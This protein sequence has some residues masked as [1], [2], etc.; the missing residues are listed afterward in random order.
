[1]EELTKEQERIIEKEIRK[2]IDKINTYLEPEDI[3]LCIQELKSSIRTRSFESFETV[4]KNIPKYAYEVV[5][6]K[7]IKR[8]LNCDVGYLSD[9]FCIFKIPIKSYNENNFEIE[10]QKINIDKYSCNKLLH[11]F[12]IYPLMFNNCIFDNEINISIALKQIQKLSFLIVFL[13]K[14]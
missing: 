10:E 3:Y 4:L 12:E 5:G 13:D 11:L 6:K 8:I 2:E 14:K 1:M 9:V 7:E